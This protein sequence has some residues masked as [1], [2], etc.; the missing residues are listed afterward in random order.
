MNQFQKQLIAVL[1][2]LAVAM[3]CVAFVIFGAVTELRSM[4]RTYKENILKPQPKPTTN[5]YLAKASLQAAMDEIDS[6]S[7][8]TTDTLRRNVHMEAFR[9]MLG[10]ADSLVDAQLLGEPDTLNHH[11]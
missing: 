2:G 5:T 4:S 10:M 9:D 11:F 6:L 8:P 3:G 1:A 7:V